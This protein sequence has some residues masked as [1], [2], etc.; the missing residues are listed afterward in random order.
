MPVSG[1]EPLSIVTIVAI[2][3]R[4][5]VA[6]LATCCMSWPSGAWKA[7]PW[8]FLYWITRGKSA[9]VRLSTNAFCSASKACHLARTSAIEV[10]GG[11]GGTEA[12]APFQRLS[13]AASAP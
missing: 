3:L 11:Y 10:S 1:G 9:S 13:Q 4:W 6:W 2:S 7:W 8:V 5:C 12:G